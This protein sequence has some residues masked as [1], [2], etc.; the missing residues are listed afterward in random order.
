[1]TSR[2]DVTAIRGAEIV[3]A[4]ADLGAAI[5]LLTERLAF[6]VDLIMPADAPALAVVSG[7]GVRLRLVRRPAPDSGHFV[8]LRLSLTEDRSC[9]LQPGAIEQVDGLRIELVSAETPVEVPAGTSHFVLTRSGESGVWGV[10]RAGM[11]YRDLLPDRLG[12]RFIASHIR[13]PHGGPVPDYVH[14][15]RIRFQMI[16]CRAGSAGLVY[17]DQGEPFAF[18]AG[19]CVLQPPEIRHRVLETSSGFEVVEIGSPAVHETHADRGLELPTGRTLP[20]RR[21]GGQTFVRHVAAHARWRAWDRCDAVDGFEARDTGIAR[22]TSGLAGAV[23]ARSTRPHARTG[24]LSYDGE[25]LFLFVLQGRA[26]IESDAFGSVDLA[27]DDCC[28]IPTGVAFAIEA[29]PACELLDVRLPGS[30]MP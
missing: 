25:F 20:E 19:D 4:C 26:R 6:A 23:V 11:L 16:Y 18:E 17:E 8:T 13:I 5:E 10:G 27:S 3:V 30:P 21:Y 22:A 28:A 24:A 2:D 12:G 9:P 7:H 15:H 14:F 1:M 29:N